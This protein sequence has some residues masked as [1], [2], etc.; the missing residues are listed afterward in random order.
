MLH[1]VAPLAA[2]LAGAAPSNDGRPSFQHFDPKQADTA[3]DPCTD[4]YAY[5]CT[6]WVKKNPIPADKGRWG[7][8]GHLAL[9][10][11]YLLRDILEGASKN[12]ASRSAA[13]QKI[14]DHYA[15]CMDEAGI[16]AKGAASLKPMM[17]RIAG[18]SSIKD[19]GPVL[20]EL[21]LATFNMLAATDSGGFTPFFIFSG[22]QDLDDASLVV[23]QVDQAGLS[24]PDRDYY[25]KTDAKSVETRTA[26]VAHVTKMFELSGEPA[27][28][29]AKDAKA[30]MDIETALA[31]GAMDLVKRRDPANINHKLQLSDVKALNPSFDWDAYLKVMQMPATKHYLVA[32]PD[33]LKAFEQQLKTRSL[34]EIKAYLRWHLIHPSAG[35]LPSQFVNE[36]FAFYGKTLAGAKELQPRWKRCSVYVD[37]DLGEALGA[38]FAQKAFP[39]TSKARMEQLVNGLKLAMAEDFHGLDWMGAATKQQAEIKLNGILDKIGY[40]EHPR[41]YA[42]VRIARDTALANA[43]SASGYELHRQLNKIGKPVDRQEWGM[44]APTVNAYYDPQMN[45]IN[46]PAGILQ[47]P[48]FDSTMDDAVNFGSIGSVIGHEMTHGFDDQGAKFDAKGNLRDWWT[49]ADTKGFEERTQCL[50]DEYSSFT[51]LDGSL[52]VN[53]NLTLGENTADN[54]GIRIAYTAW[55]AAMK[56]AGKKVTPADEKRFFLAYGE[57]WC[58]QWSDPALRMLVQTNP[59]SPN[60]FRVNGVLRNVP[61]FQQAFQCKPGSPMAPEKRC[62]VW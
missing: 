55:L 26:Y 8:G 31:N 1:L 27:A 22:G 32:V 36:D 59:H 48:F 37:R 16:D 29:A 13:E 62:R 23:A 10:N 33:A 15:A 11:Q 49:A 60:Q 61:E 24:L 44:T 52:H 14:G 7:V 38:V 18:M 43:W 46:F 28:Q 56:H 58:G 20:A 54:G 34:D 12:S 21:H 4:F 25:T 2:L 53:G 3:V 57:S 5:A 35:M 51:V 17:D 40:P 45:T 50:A 19:L 30:V 39:A 9:A 6:N 41:D 47:P 42:T